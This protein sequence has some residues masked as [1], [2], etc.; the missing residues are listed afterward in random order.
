MPFERVVFRSGARADR[1]TIR[2][3]RVFTIIA[4][5][6][7]AI[8]NF[9]MRLTLSKKIFLN[10]VIVVVLFGMV[11]AFLGAKVITRTTVREAQRRVRLDLRSA[12][13][14]LNGELDKLSLLLGAV[15]NS[16]ELAKALQ[17]GFPDSQTVHLEA[18]GKRYNIDFLTVTDSEGRAVIRAVEP[19]NI[20]D[21]RSNDPFV[22]A[23]LKGGSVS[24]FVILGQDRLRMEGRDLDERSYIVFEPTS[25]AKPRAKTFETSGMALLASAPVKDEQGVVIGAIYGGVLLNRNHQLTDRIRSDVFED[26]RYDGEHLGTV[27]IF[28]WDVRIATNVTLTNGNRAIGTRV[29]AEV[30]DKVLENKISYYDRAFVVNSDYISAYDPISDL[31]GKVIG[32]LYV[33]V[34]AK[35]YDDMKRG[36]WKLY[37]G[38]AAGLAVVGITVG[39]IF[40]NRLS[41]SL[42]RLADATGRITRGD[43][44]IYLTEPSANDE[45]R[46]LTQAF[47]I[48][49]ASL[50]DREERLTAAKAELERTNDSLHKINASYLDMLRFVSHEL[51]NTLGVIYTS[52][53]TLQ[54]LLAGPLDEKQKRLVD[55]ISR[56]IDS[57][58]SM[59]RKYLDLARI[60]KG[61]MPVEAR[62]IE[63]TEEVLKPILDEL[64]PAVVS[65][66]ISVL[67]RLAVPLYVTADPAL[68]RIVFKNL[69]DNALKYGRDGGRIRIDGRPENGHVLFE[70]WN[71]GKGLGPEQIPHLFKKFKRF[72]NDAEASP[73]GT[74]LGL[75]LTKEIVERHGGKI[76]AESKEGEWIRFL[77]TAPKAISGES[78]SS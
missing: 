74:G 49:A 65:H 10:F 45:I 60:E 23:A 61:E 9:P 66:R 72:Q 11:S 12:W 28:Q 59:T 67:N 44:G 7:R 47:N 5:L 35:Q 38:L 6:W 52:A 68:L 30:Y 8:E 25:K 29:S 58:L 18:L 76:R 16:K 54:S 14:V 43:L 70:V 46:D 33:G 56:S 17:G 27:T 24:G 1:S 37:S 50:K 62:T 51:K 39:L 63:V 78:A 32:I 13:G 26:Q 64:E 22:G 57:A 42:R 53:K 3:K 36:L 4:A 73:K 19:H 15:G 20:G 69:L 48:M 55:S 71:E 21:D 41:G 2:R 40:S 31:D 75:F 34:L 77:F